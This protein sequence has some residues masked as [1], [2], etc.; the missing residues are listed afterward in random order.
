MLVP[1]R[2]ARVRDQGLYFDGL[3]ARP[4]KVTINVFDHGLQIHGEKG[5]AL[6]IWS[7]HGLRIETS[8]D[9]ATEANLLMHGDHPDAPRQSAYQV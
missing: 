1:S 9:S 2:Y 3:T 4:H 8:L 5:E 7:F 6:G